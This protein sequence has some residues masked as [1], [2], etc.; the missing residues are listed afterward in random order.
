MTG[1]DAEI[2]CGEWETGDIPP[3]KTGEKY[4][5]VMNI[6]EIIQ[7]P[8]Y[9][10]NTNSSAYLENDIA[11]FKVDDK[12]LSK[13]HKKWKIYPACLPTGKRSTTEGFHSGWSSPIPFNILRNFSPGFT[14]VFRDF[15]K[16][17]HYRMN[18]FEQ[19]TDDNFFIGT[20]DPVFSPTDTF[21]PPG[22]I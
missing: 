8:D 1:K 16:Q 7:H 12:I 6:K 5:V 4:N 11:V 22:T 21:Y 20:I 13:L 15:F 18:I 17:I 19:C 2:I 3:I 14:T 9:T 10:V